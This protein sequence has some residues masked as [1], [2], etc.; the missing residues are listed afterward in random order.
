MTRAPP[1]ASRCV[2]SSISV[3]V[4]RLELIPDVAAAEREMR[5]RDRWH[6]LGR[7]AEQHVAIERDVGD[8]ARQ[9]AERVERAGGFHDAVHAVLAVG[10]PIAEHAAE[11]SR[12]DGRAGGLGADRERHHEVGDRG[13]RAARRPGRGAGEV[14]RIAG[15]SGMQVGEFG[16]DGLAEEDAAGLARQ[17]DAGGVALGLAAPMNGRSPLGRHVKGVDDVLGA[18]RHAADRAA[19][20]VLVEGTGGR[21]APL[22]DRDGPRHAPRPRARRCGRDR[23]ASPP[24]SWC[25]PGR[26][27]RRSRSRSVR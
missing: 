19:L 13:G 10:R 11:R 6:R 16:G 5:P 25:G 9:D 17:R 15:R 4:S 22:R 12:P 24:R 2:A 1:R 18:E 3:R 14:M 8:R 7:D 20:A 26:S 27:L 21:R 23:R